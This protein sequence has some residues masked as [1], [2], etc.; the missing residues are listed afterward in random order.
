HTVASLMAARGRHRFAMLR[1]EMLEEAAAAEAA[2]V[3]LLSVPPAMIMD[4]RFREVAPNA[5]AFPGENFY[6]IGGTGDFLRWAMPLVKHGAD[7]VY[8][9]GSLATVRALADH[10]IPVC[11][12]VGLI[13]S[14]RTWTGGFRAVGKTLDSA[15]RVWEQVNE[16]EAAGAFAAEI[17]VVPHQITEAIAGKTSLFLVS[18]GG[19]AG[20][21]AQYLFTDD[22]LG[23]NRGHVPRHAKVYANFAAEYD[24]LQQ[25]RIAAMRAFAD[26]VHGGAYPSGEYL[27][28]AGAEVVAAFR[29]WLSTNG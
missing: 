8:C 5:F 26:D 1:V 23:Q 18:M 29:D 21:H 7:G 10:A 11:G 14:K 20:G 22:V 3:E 25:M 28:E 2:A 19:G 16:L 27:V 9:S 12:H 6:E 15:K 24:R 13:P 4:S 17:E